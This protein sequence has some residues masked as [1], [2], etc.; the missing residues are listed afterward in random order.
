[1][2]ADRGSAVA[3]G[4]EHRVAVVTRV[5]VEDRPLDGEAE[6]LNLRQTARDQRLRGEGQHLPRTR[7]SGRLGRLL[8]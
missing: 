5:A 6:L 2:L 7:V 4:R 8:E 3:T 1:M